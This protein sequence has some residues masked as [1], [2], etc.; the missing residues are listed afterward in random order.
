MIMNTAEQRFD[1]SGMTCSAC[2]ARV[3][4]VVKKQSGVISAQVNLLT[5]GMS[6][7]YD[8]AVCSDEDI[9]N[10]VARAGYS[11]KLHSD[12]NAR[13]KLKNDGEAPADKSLR[14]M[15]KRLIW[16]IVFTLPLFYISMG[17]MLGF[18]LPGFMHGNQNA[19]TFAFTQFLFLIPIIFINI[20]YFK[21]GFKN[22]FRLS[23]NMDSLIAI[24]SF[25][26]AVYGI[27]AIYKIGYGLG[28]GL[29]DMVS[30]Y[31]MDLYFESAG[32]ILTLI[33]LG[34]FLE[35]RAKSKTT[36][37]ITKLIKL[38]PDSAVVIKDGKELTINA[39]ELLPG[40]IIAV[41]PGQTI[42]VDGEVVSG[43]SSVDESA[44]TG[45]SIPVMKN[46]GDKVTGGC[47]NINGFFTFKAT[48]VG[49]DTA[50]SQIIQLVE[51]AASSKAPIAR[52]ADKISGVFVPIVIAVA[53]AAAVIWLLLGQSFEFAMSVGISVL[54]ISC[55]C[56]LG[57]ATPT[58]IMVGTGKGA[59]NGVL[60]KSAE[61]LETAHKIDAV[62]LDKTGTITYGKPSVTDV[63]PYKTDSGALLKYALSVERLSEHP[64]A[65]AVT[66]YADSHGIVPVPA[67]EFENIPGR[68][69]S[70]NVDGIKV[71]AGNQKLLKENGIKYDDAKADIAKLSKAGKTLLFFAAD[72]KFAGM[73]A[74]AD[75]V[76][77]SS[78]KAVGALH[79]MGIDTVMLTGDSQQTA[80]AIQ[81]ECGV[82]KVAAELLPQDKE[83]QI[84]Q[85]QSQGKCVAMV[86]DGI[87]DSPALARADVGIAIGAGTDI[88]VDSADVVLVKNDLTDVAYMIKLSRATIK[89]IKENLFWALIYNSLGIPLAAGVFYGVWGIKLSPMFGAAAM[90]LSSVCVVS[91]ALRLK[92]FN[93]KFN[94]KNNKTKAKENKSM[95]KTVTIEGMMCEHCSARVEQALN[96]LNGAEAAVDLK[97]K[98]ACVKFADNTPEN[99]DELIKKA[100]EDA[101]YT[102]TSIK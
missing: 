18:P 94:N 11:A 102:V 54:V 78:P 101:G 52:L 93:P 83:A 85:L 27:F 57:L 79:S 53:V 44:L 50:L 5:G 82:K 16:S 73:I 28:H 36:D 26:A 70:A 75:T 45:E 9:I 100:I 62:V 37:A 41:K 68:G 39:D 58:A 51:A 15:K 13:G 32:V 8:K 48:K 1:V 20:N 47:V 3:E 64:L 72:E 87:N 42:P 65:F 61:A 24:G 34:K 46:P 56:A 81:K 7:I 30:H 49:E 17:H 80:L 63:L 10:S 4:S 59:Q 38:R 95:I 77:P 21:N 99:A 90:S 98:T 97:S 6:V 33:T 19:L 2:S 67:K 29:D 84:R 12:K 14:L 71:L 40:D 31:S 22:L 89:N 35:T 60:I 66:E 69:V 25:A 92:F 23:P 88:A 76:K 86:G 43:S 96:Q 55:P 91:N 74:A